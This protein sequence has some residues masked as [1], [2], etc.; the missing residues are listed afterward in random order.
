MEKLNGITDKKLILDSASMSL[1]RQGS[2]DSFTS[3]LFTE[4]Y[5]YPF[6]QTLFALRRTNNS[7]GISSGNIKENYTQNKRDRESE[8]ERVKK[9]EGKR[10]T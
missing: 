9:K 2:R 8:R 7:R 1:Q 6:S 3:L 5:A 10:E 4:K